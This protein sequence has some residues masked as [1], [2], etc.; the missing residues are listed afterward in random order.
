[1]VFWAD[2]P[3]ALSGTLPLLLSVFYY[4]SLFKEKEIVIGEGMRRWRPLPGGN[5]RIKWQ[6][7]LREAKQLWKLQRAKA[8]AA[9]AAR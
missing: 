3:L 9:A 7:K 5:T 2:T 6:P 1:M 8:A 4:I